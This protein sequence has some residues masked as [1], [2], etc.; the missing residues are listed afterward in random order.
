MSLSLAVGDAASWSGDA[1]PSLVLLPPKLAKRPAHSAPLSWTFVMSVAT[2]ILAQYSHNICLLPQGRR[3]DLFP[4]LAQKLGRGY[5]TKGP[6]RGAPMSEPW[7]EMES[8]LWK[9]RPSGFGSA[10]HAV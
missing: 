2:Q 1:K 5:V 3:Q 7:E 8:I 4:S 9:S 6:T 10:K